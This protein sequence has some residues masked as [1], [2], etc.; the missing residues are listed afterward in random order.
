MQAIKIKKGKTF[1]WPLRW[2]TKPVIFKAISGITQA[3]PA[4]VHAPS[5]GLVDGWRVAVM[6]VKGMLAINAPEDPPNEEDMR[7]VTVVDDDHVSLDGVDSSGMK[8]YTSGGF[9]RFLTPVDLSGYTARAQIKDR[10]G[11]TELL[12]LTDDNDRIIIND[13]EHK[14]TVFINAVDTAALDFRSGIMDLELVSASGIV[15]ALIE[16]T[17]I[18]VE[19]EVTTS[20]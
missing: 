9:L 6:S 11:G 8:P 1:N 14:I 7:V 13:S 17:R 19:D 12:L 10:I 20:T 5:H 4:V 15:T 16:P 2:E 18:I 3:A